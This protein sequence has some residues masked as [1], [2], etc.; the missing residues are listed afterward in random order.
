ME[1]FMTS[2]G[3]RQRPLVAGI[4]T[5]LLAGSLISLFFPAVRVAGIILLVVWYAVIAYCWD[6]QGEFW[7]GIYNAIRS[8]RR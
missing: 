2:D 3:K 5:A 4:A 8:R 6:L 7:R 1:L